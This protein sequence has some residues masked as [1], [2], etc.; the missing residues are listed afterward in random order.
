MGN[1]GLPLIFDYLVP[2]VSL[3]FLVYLVHLVYLVCL[4]YSFKAS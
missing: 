3:V 2:L 1:W 4:V